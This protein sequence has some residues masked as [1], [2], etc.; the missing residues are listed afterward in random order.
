MN[1][2]WENGGNRWEL[3]KV[4]CVHQLM[5]SDCQSQQ[6]EQNSAVDDPAAN[7]DLIFR[8]ARKKNRKQKTENKKTLLKNMHFVPT[9]FSLQVI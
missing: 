4:V 7:T 1:S 5:W 3:E 9:L 6:R 2:T 8:P